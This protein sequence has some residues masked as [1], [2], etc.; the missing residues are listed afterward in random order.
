MTR[1]KKQPKALDFAADFE[2]GINLRK[3][4]DNNKKFDE[5]QKCLEEY[6]GTKRAAFPRFYF[7]SNDE[8]LEIL[9]QTRNVHAVQP[10]LIKCFDAMKKVKFTEVP[11][12]KTITGMYSPEN[13]YIPWS[14]IVKAEG[15]VEFWLTDIEK[16]MTQ[17]L[18]DATKNAVN[19]YPSNGLERAEWLFHCGAQPILTVDMIMWTRNCESAIYEI[20]QGKNSQALKEFLDFSDK[21]LKNMIKLVRGKLNPLNRS[22][23]GALIVLDVHALEVVRNM[24]AARVENINDFPWTSQLRYYWEDILETDGEP[25]K[26]E[27]TG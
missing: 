1:A 17:S 18:Y 15:G 10:H 24:I 22:V 14:G 21:Q 4:V 25:Y 5:I 6:L 20:M 13:E 3:F 11:D 27:N 19:I 26:G 23:M 9:S 7:L 12:S 8:M 16:M 2:V